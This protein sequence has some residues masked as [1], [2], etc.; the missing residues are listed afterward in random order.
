MKAH[1]LDAE[2]KSLLKSYEKDEWK[3]TKPGKAELSRYASYA[4]TTL[5]KDQRINIRLSQQDLHGIQVK[6]VSEGIP[7]QTLIASILHKYVSGRLASR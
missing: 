3:S 1:K 7:Y 6:A 4:H 2:E 5:R